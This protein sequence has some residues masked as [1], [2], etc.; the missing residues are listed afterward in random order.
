M[1]AGLSLF[2]GVDRLHDPRPIVEP[3]IAYAVLGFS[4]IVIGLSV[5]SAVAAYNARGLQ[6]RSF[7]ALRSSNEPAL[8]SA[9]VQQCSVLTSAAVAFAGVLASHRLAIAEADGLAAIAIGL[10]MAA[11]AALLSLE[12]RALIAS[13]P[14]GAATP[15]RIDAA[16]RDGEAR[17]DPARDARSTAAE[18]PARTEPTTSTA[19]AASAATHRNSA[20]PYVTF[21]TVAQKI[22]ALWPLT[23]CAAAS[24]PGQPPAAWPLPCSD[25]RRTAGSPGTPIIPATSSAIA[26][27]ATRLPRTFQCQS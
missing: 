4:A 9:L 23:A 7:A 2:A 12:T 27:P 13:Q 5:W 24:L 8:F 22:E 25:T 1:G 18:V 14:V 26:A 6:L 11:T 3:D 10:V 21:A 16:L 17:A 20:G 15:H 19:S